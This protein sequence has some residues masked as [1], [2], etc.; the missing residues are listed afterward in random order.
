[1]ADADGPRE[2]DYFIAAGGGTFH[3]LFPGVT[4]RTTAGQGL[5]LSVVTFEPNGVVPDHAHPR[6]QMGIMISGR[7][8]FTVGGLTKILGPGDMW[9]IPGGVRHKVV[10]LD[11][12][13]V[14]LDVF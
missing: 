7:A 9:R 6:E 8:E 5:M 3:A 4:I 11:G 13:A 2:G 1:M 14:A 10:G 12:P